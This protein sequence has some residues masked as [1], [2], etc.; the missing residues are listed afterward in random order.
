MGRRRKLKPETRE[1]M[2]E[3]AKARAERES[4]SGTGRPGSPSSSKLYRK[5]TEP[6][7]AILQ[8]KQFLRWPQTHDELDLFVQ[9][10]W[11]YRLPRTAVCPGHVAPFDAFA[12]AFFA[13]EPV[14]VWEASRGFGGKTAM[15]SVLCL[16]EALTMG[17]GVVIL[18]GSGAQSLNVHRATDSAWEAPHA[19]RK[20]IT[21]STTFDTV[22]NNGGHIRSLTASETSVRGPH[23]LR[24]RLDEIDEMSLKILESAQGQPMKDRLKPQLETQT[25][26]SSTHQYPDGT[27]TAILKRADENGWPVN[28]WCYKETS[29]PHDGW[30]SATEIARKRK[31]ITAAM[32]RTEYDLQEPSFAGRAIDTACVEAAFDPHFGTYPG[33]EHDVVVTEQPGQYDPNRFAPY[34]TGVDWA[35]EHDYTVVATFK[36]DVTPWQCV[37]WKRYRRVPWPAAVNRAQMQWRKYGGRFVHDSTGLGGVIDDYLNVTTAERSAKVIV[38]QTLGGLSRKA[39]FNEY[40]AGI[41]AGQI[42]YPRIEWAFDEHRYVTEN[43]LFG[44][45]HPPDSFVAGALAWSLRP[46]TVTRHTGVGALP[47]TVGGRRSGWIGA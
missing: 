41:E 15:L 25:V 2:S 17:C 32:W 7:V 40:I 33:V 31:E 24:L 20:M 44:T 12:Q 13:D 35:K 42:V 39:M 46:P 47:I 8:E 23:P 21:K 10:V 18:G 5:T 29:N 9:A 37:A 22:L 38:A 30:L 26:M 6:P 3:S 19:P 14:T 45:G 4:R 34:I 27:M 43:D 36:T 1:K 11:G 16:T 28:K